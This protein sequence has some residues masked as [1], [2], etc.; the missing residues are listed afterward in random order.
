MPSIALD[1]SRIRITTFSP[2]MV[3]NVLTR[4]SI[5]FFFDKASFIRPS[6]G[7]RR[8]A[9]SNFD[10]TFKR[11]AIREASDTGGRATSVKIPSMRKRIR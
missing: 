5:D 2:H 10:I 1:E 3:G 4:K 6:C 11:A 9:I 7:T 8:S